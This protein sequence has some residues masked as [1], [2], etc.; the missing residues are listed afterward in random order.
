MNW[1]V[2]SAM[3]AVTA[4]GFQAAAQLNLAPG[5]AIEKRIHVN[6]EPSYFFKVNGEGTK[7]AFTLY[8]NYVNTGEQNYM[9]D[10]TGDASNRK[11]QEIPGSFDPMFNH[12][13]KSMTIPVTS[14]KK[15]V[16]GFYS[17]KEVASKG[18]EAEPK[19][20]D[21][22]M[23]CVYQS[24]G[25][26]S[27]DEKR[28]VFRLIV[29]NESGFA[30]RDYEEDKS[31]GRIRPISGVKTLCPG[32]TIKLPMISKDGRE[33]G[34]YG[35]VRNSSVIFSV[36]DDGSCTLKE[37]LKVRAGKIAFSYDGKRVAYH[38]FSSSDPRLT[39]EFIE[40]P[41]DGY[42]ADVFVYNRE[43]GKTQQITR[44]SRSNSLFPEFMRDGR[45]I[46]IDHPHDGEK[47]KVS[48]VIM[49]PK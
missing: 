41:G 24:V 42:V 11:A 3:A 21:Y 23:R 38:V 48:F 6:Y 8:R 39:T 17:E 40:V 13:F 16:C 32:Y 29:E 27:S 22:D 31:T 47:S 2:L 1:R 34:A 37:D 49:R 4:V 35:A 14:A 7:V 46:F 5:I 33:L 44:N 19:Y 20:V 15:F 10:I 12:N 18:R 25:L 9:L 36:A 43:T 30:M 26:L 28:D 45:V